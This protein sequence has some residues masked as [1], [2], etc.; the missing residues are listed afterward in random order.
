MRLSID[1]LRVDSYATQMSENEL[2]AVKGGTTPW[3]VYV[4][5]ALVAAGATVIVAAIAADNDHKEC[6]TREWTDS[7]GVKHTQH[8]CRE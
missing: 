5:V 2:T 3:C 8:I 1:D 7:H 4:G 6:G